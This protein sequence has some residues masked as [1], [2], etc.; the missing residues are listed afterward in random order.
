M[1]ALISSNKPKTSAKNVGEEEVGGN[2]F[3]VIHLPSAGGALGLVFVVLLLVLVGWFTIRRCRRND[4]ALALAHLRAKA[5]GKMGRD[6]PEGFPMMPLG[7]S[8]YQPPIVISAPPMQHPMA[9]LSL[10]PWAPPPMLG[11]N[12]TSTPRRYDDMRIE[13]LTDEPPM[14]RGAPTRS[15][16]T[17]P[18]VELRVAATSTDD[19]R[20]CAATGSH[21]DR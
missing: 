18:D 9:P 4:K 10:S 11:Y 15:R 2:H 8:P 13:E 21:E 7:H 1:G 12:R 17:S 3:E 5:G 14:V 16:A 20:N 19:R 6:D